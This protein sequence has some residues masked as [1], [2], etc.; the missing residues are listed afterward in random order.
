MAIKLKPISE[1]EFTDQ[2]IAVLQLHG[3]LVVHFR[4]ARKANGGWMTPIKGNAGSPDIIAAKFG[5]VLMAELK[6]GRNK[7]TPEQSLW[8]HHAGKHAYLWYPKHWDQIVLIAQK[9]LGI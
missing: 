8:L 9:G 5:Q 7:P 6:V 3:W 2:V 1:D 4:K